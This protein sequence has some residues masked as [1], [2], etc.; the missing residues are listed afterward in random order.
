[1]MNRQSSLAVLVLLTFLVA[2]ASAP[3]DRIAYTSISA[4][5]DGVQAALKAWNEGYYVPG[6]KVDPV[7]WNASRDKLNAAY[8]Q[9]QASAQL[10]TTIAQD[11][12]NK[13]AAQKIINDAASQIVTLISLLEK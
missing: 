7:K 10:A 2:C 9:F 3:P 12:A 4:A 1:M 6:V 13:D 8:A 5:V 11:V